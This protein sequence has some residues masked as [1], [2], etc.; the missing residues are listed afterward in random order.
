MQCPKQVT[1]E[2]LPVLPHFT[3][4]CDAGQTLSRYFWPA[5]H[6]YNGTRRIR[7]SKGESAIKALADHLSISVLYVSASCLG[8][9]M[10][11]QPTF[12]LLWFVL[13]ATQHHPL[14]DC[15]HCRKCCVCSTSS[16]VFFNLLPK[17][18]MAICKHKIFRRLDDLAGKFVYLQHKWQADN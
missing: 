7:N 13:P 2:S 3:L 18:Y 17:W 10:V 4:L 16:V 12:C 1:S 11:L 8:V 15:V 14:H 6:I 9:C 5:R